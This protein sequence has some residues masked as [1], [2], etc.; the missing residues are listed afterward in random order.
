M[1]LPDHWLVVRLNALGDVV[2][3]TGVLDRWY[4]ERGWRFSFLTFSGW[5]P[6]LEGHPAID[7]II[8]VEKSALTPVGTVTLFRRLAHELK[9]H[10]LLDLHGSLRS[11][12]LRLFW[13]GEARH[14]PKYS[15][16]RRIFLQSKGK[17]FAE[18]L[19]QYNVPQRYALAVDAEAPARSDVLPRIFLTDAERD[20]AYER[21]RGAVRENRPLVALHPY[22]THENKAWLA[23]NWRS[24]AARL[25]EDGND[26]LVVGRG[27]PFLNGIPHVHDLTNATHLRETCALLAAC[28]VLVTGDSG[29]MHLAGGVDTPVVAL[30]GPTHA[31]W[32]FYPEGPRDVVLESPADCRPCSLHGSKPCPNGHACMESITT[33]QVFATVMDVLRHDAS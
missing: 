20:A 29:P 7:R 24:L 3:T 31:V 2:L 32:G 14:Y 30:F 6:V 28:D 22:S 11:R 1:H 21:L 18:R 15:I 33:E 4:R 13:P 8:S 16:E 9:G 17:M 27:Q 23:S 19:M 5:A 10:G 12:M 26:V 25:A